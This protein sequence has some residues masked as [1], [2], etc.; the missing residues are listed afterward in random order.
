M[1]K[2]KVNRKDEKIFIECNKWRILIKKVVDWN[3]I[4]LS[5]KGLDVV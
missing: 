1:E 4:V 2:N 5:K 3:I